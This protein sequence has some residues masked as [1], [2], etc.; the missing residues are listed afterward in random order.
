MK[1]LRTKAILAISGGADSMY[2]LDHY[3]NESDIVVA[4]VNYNIRDDSNEDVKIVVDFCNQ[5]NIP[6]RSIS[7]HKPDNVNLEE[8]ARNVRY[9][10]FKDLLNE[11]KYDW[12]ITAHNADD[13]AETVLMRIQRG[14]GVKGLSGIIIDKKPFY[15]PML[16]ITKSDVYKYCE[17]HNVPFREDSTNTDTTYRRNWFRHVYIPSLEDRESSV[18][19]LCRIAEISQNVSDKILNHS[20]IAFD[21]VVTI[22]GNTITIPKTVVGDALFFTYLQDLLSNY[23]INLSQTL[24]KN[25]FSSDPSLNKIT[26]KE[27]IINKRKIRNI[28]LIL[29][30]F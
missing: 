22:S 27:L 13:Q 26:T 19:M 14:T 23:N 30:S 12:I 8:W 10:F 15:R 16:S 25:I 7:V 29:N 21:S 11:F 9:D 4:T 5:Y 1:S 18:S 6:F 20:H 28:E 24:F 2:L 3:K 17:L